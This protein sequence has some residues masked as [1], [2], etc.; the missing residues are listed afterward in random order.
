MRMTPDP[1]FD[2]GNMAATTKGDVGKDFTDGEV[3]NPNDQT[4]N[5]CMVSCGRVCTCMYVHMSYC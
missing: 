4:K 2:I 5:G 1:D 3:S